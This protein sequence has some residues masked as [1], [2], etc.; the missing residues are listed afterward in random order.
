MDESFMGL[1]IRSK[2]SWSRDYWRNWRTSVLNT[3]SCFSFFYVLLF[4]SNGKA[5]S[6]WTT[7]LHEWTARLCAAAR[8]FLISSAL[9]FFLLPHFKRSCELD[10]LMSEYRSFVR[11]W[12]PIKKEGF[13]PILNSLTFLNWNFGLEAAM[14]MGVVGVKMKSN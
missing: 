14:M 1:A 11:A 9:N 7:N 13:R 2:C 8:S 5:H 3:I 10:P 6:S 4:G 12:T